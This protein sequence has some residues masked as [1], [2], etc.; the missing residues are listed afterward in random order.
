MLSTP[1][2]VKIHLG[3]PLADHS[4]D[5]KIG[6]ILESVSAWIE[7]RCNRDFRYA[8]WTEFYD[9]DD[10]DTLQLL[11]YPVDSHEPLTLSVKGK[12]VNVVT[13]LATGKMGIDYGNGSIER[14]AGFLAGRRTHEVT[15]SAGYI[16]PSD[17]SG[18]EESTLPADLE[19]AAIR[20]TARI[21]ER[22]TAEGV[23][24]ASA[25]GLS[26]NYNDALDKDIEETLATYSRLVIV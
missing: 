5:A 11:H 10:G 8:E 7:K 6:Q 19:L 17:E 22:A 14:D 21:V 25:G 2:K 23:S 24:S 15:Y 4:K 26:I 16:L 12:I 13:E 3:I 20:L 1:E 9:G 18:A